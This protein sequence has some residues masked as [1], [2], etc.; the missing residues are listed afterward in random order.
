MSVLVTGNLVRHPKAADFVKRA[1]ITGILDRVSGTDFWGNSFDERSAFLFEA[2]ARFL[3]CRVWLGNST[4]HRRIRLGVVNNGLDFQ[5]R[6][7]EGEHVDQAG[8]L[9]RSF[10]EV[11]AI[12]HAPYSRDAS[13]LNA[14]VVFYGDLPAPLGVRNPYLRVVSMNG[15]EIFSYKRKSC[16]Q[17]D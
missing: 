10:R 3:A 15:L 17:T 4:F 16:L 6:G 11:G 14:T 1:V 13:D 2:E 12:I 9:R 7:S 8:N 5:I